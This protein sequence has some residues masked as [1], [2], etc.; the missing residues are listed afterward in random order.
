MQ[1]A[2]QPESMRL[3]DKGMVQRCATREESRRDGEHAFGL[4]RSTMYLVSRQV[5]KLCLH[6]FYQ[7]SRIGV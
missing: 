2:V 7:A 6:V 5:N 1:D 3:C 4:N